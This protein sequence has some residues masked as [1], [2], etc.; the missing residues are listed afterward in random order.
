[1]R[2]VTSFLHSRQALAWCLALTALWSITPAQ[3]QNPPVPCASPV[4][5]QF[6][7]WLGEWEVFM[8]DGK[9]AGENT[10]E[11]VHGG[12]ALRE[13]WRGG[14]KVEGTSLNSVNVRSA[15][16]VQHWVDNQGGRLFLVGGM[17]GAQM[18]LTSVEHPDFRGA[19]PGMDRVTWT[20]LEGGAVRQLWER[21]TDGG[22]TWTVSFDGKYVRKP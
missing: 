6:D 17:Q 7:F 8:P 2:A 4:Q 12:C 14:G 13:T 20:P 9:K 22:A 10:I 11:R 3:A 21:S 19:L 5:R 18:V 1:M 15:R 16:W